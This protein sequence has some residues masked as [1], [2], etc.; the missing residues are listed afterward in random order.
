MATYTE[1]YSLLGDG[2]AQELKNK[3]RIAIIIAAETI[4]AGNDGTD[5]PWDQTNHANRLKW[6]KWAFGNTEQAFKEIF[7]TVIAA[8][9][10]SALTAIKTANDSTVQDNVNAVVDLFAD[11]SQ[12]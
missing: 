4:R 3:I 2:E 9:D 10:A 12:V 11:G 1:L 7:W 6:A 8:N 5:P